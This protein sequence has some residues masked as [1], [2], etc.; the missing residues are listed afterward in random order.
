MSATDCCDGAMCAPGPLLHGDDG[1][2]R[3]ERRLLRGTTCTGGMCGPV[4]RV[5]RGGPG[6]LRGR[7]LP[8]GLRVRLGMCSACGTDG[9]PCCPG[10]TCTGTLACVA[11]QC[12]TPPPCGDRLQPCCAG[13]SC[14]PASR[15]TRAPA[16]RPRG[17]RRRRADVLR[18]RLQPGPQL[19]GRHHL[20]DGHGDAR[21]L[22]RHGPDVLRRHAC[23][24]GLTC[25]RGTCSMGTGGMPAPCGGNGE[26]CCSGVACNS[27]LSCT[28]GVCSMSMTGGMDAGGGPPAPRP[29]ATRASPAAARSRATRASPA[30]RAPASQGAPAPVA[31]PAPARTGPAP[32]ATQGPAPAPAP[33]P[34]LGRAPARNRRRRPRRGRLRRRR[35][36]LLRLGRVQRHARVH[37]RHLPALLGHVVRRDGPALLRHPRRASRASPAG[38]A[39]TC[40]MGAGV[41]GGDGQTCCSGNT[42][43]NAAFQCLGGTC[44][45]C[46]SAG[47]VV[48]DDVALLRGPH[49]QRG[50]VQ[51]RHDA[52]PR[53]RRLHAG[54]TMCASGTMCA[55]A[56]GANRCCRAE[57]GT[58]MTDNECCGE[59]SC[60]SGRCA[61]HDGRLVHH[62]RRLHLGPGC[63]G[64]C[65]R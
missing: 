52:D 39:R 26:T 5:R 6:V 9:Q 32:A 36:A 18:H 65:A 53:G 16:R 27:G 55:Q 4:G 58:C 11:D 3:L 29:A 46:N 40:Q 60:R 25:S 28:G 49:L 47:T 56:Q 14:N 7:H 42:C 13:S 51:Q 63:R 62:Q 45:R 19:R 57:A 12:T 17:L 10:S 15:A 43:T 2:L 37:G 34:A 64:A 31:A 21:P 61:Q 54:M 20:P 33:A 41:C 22:R 8:G 44:Q 59:L 24:S 50:H 48:L 1:P 35:R 23:N 38:H 30:R